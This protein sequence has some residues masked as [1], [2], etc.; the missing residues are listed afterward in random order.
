M[1]YKCAIFDLDG[2]LID[3]LQ[4][5]LDAVNLTFKELGFNVRR[6]YEEAK[7]FIGAGAVEF[8]IR[9]MKGKNI[10]IEK[11]REV[12]DKFLVNYGK[13]QSIVTKPFKGIFLVLEK[14]QKSG[15]KVCIASNKPQILLDPVIKQ[16]FPNFKFDLALGSRPKKPEK[17]DPFMVFEIINKFKLDPKDCVYIGDSE[18]D[19]KTAHNAGIDLVITKYGYG[20]YNEPWMKNVKQSVD[21]VNELE[22]RLLY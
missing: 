2:T 14:L 7:Y 22:K 18:Y 4:G 6:E 11:E 10:P 8:A 5:I 9:A 17:P 1:K 3:S 16:L 13:M 12:M 19:Y 20:F 21:T 15:M